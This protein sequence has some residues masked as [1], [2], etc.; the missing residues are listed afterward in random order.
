MSRFLLTGGNG[1]VGQ[2]L[3]R[4]LL[5]RGHETTGAGLGSWETSPAILTS[6][7]RGA[8][9]WI[10]ADM[11]QQ[12]DVNAMLDA[13]RPDVVVHLAGIAFQP[14][15]D[16]NPTLAYDVNVLGAVRL[17][18]ALNERREAGTLD[19]ATLIVGTGL[20]YGVHAADEQP[21][22]EEAEQRPLT[23]YAASK[24]AQETVALQ[25]FRS[26]GASIVCTR[27]FNHSGA[28]QAAEYLL[29][30]LVGRTLALRRQGGAGGTLAL[31]NDVTRDYLHVT[32]VA[33]AYLALAERGQSGEVYNVCSGTGIGV[34]QLAA[35]V[36]LRGGV[37]AE[38]STAPSLVRATDIPALVGSPAKLMRDTG[39]SP[40]KTPADIIDDLLNAATE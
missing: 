24:M 36:L 13:S 11:R 28:G 8:V 27:S 14:H 23:A 10:A 7:E 3:T 6:E 19:A 18:A 29:P 37:S 25:T 32:D 40:R 15:G 38:I 33:E 5:E 31:G 16:Q 21:L 35:D 1:F 20:Q 2:W 26:G 12:G 17:F 30:A 34:R 9:Q 4:L 39:W 22:A